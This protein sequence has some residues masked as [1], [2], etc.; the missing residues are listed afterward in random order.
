MGAQW[1]QA[2]QQDDEAGWVEECN[3]L[4][5]EAATYGD[6]YETLPGMQAIVLG[7]VQEANAGSLF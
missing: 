1:W 3:L 2:A 6:S 7:Q 5:D 4:A